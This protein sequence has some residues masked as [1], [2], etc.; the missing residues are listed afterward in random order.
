M[1]A[2]LLANIKSTCCICSTLIPP[3][4]TVSLNMLC[5][6]WQSDVTDEG[7]LSLAALT[8][9]HSLHLGGAC[10]PGPAVCAALAHCLTGLTSLQLTNCASLAD[11]ALFKLAPLA[12][13]LRRLGLNGCSGVT[14]IGLVALLKW[15]S[16]L[17][18]LE[19]AGCHRNITGI[20]LQVGS[21]RRLKHLNLAGCD[22]ITGER[23]QGKFCTAQLLV[24]C[25]L[26]RT[27]SLLPPLVFKTPSHLHPPAPA[28]G[29]CCCCR[30][31]D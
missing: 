9:L 3:P 24:C 23:L 27:C 31:G 6:P 15:A 20:G 14:D 11:A 30:C 13:G 18:H 4:A 25:Q 2:S 26:C 7:L 22:A 17:T 19:L 28:C 16:R 1:L 8:Q 10:T 12:P 29:L 21:L 5:R